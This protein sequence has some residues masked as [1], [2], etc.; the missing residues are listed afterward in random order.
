M[1]GP[2]PYFNFTKRTIEALRPPKRQRA[3]YRDTDTR[4][5]GLLVQ[6]SG[7]RSFIWYRKVQGR[8]TWRT[9]GFFPELSI[10]QARKAAAEYNAGIAAWK[11]DSYQGPAPTERPRDLTLGIVLE[12]YCEKRL[13][14][15]SKNPERAMRYA[16]WQF[17]TY[18]A[19]WR[20]R[21]LGSIQRADVRDMQV[22]VG[23]KHGRFTANRVLQ[24]VRALFNWAR[25][26]EQWNGEN[27]AANIELY[28]EASRERFVQPAEAPKLFQALAA[29]SNL[30]LRDYVLL[31][32]FTGARK[33]DVLGMRWQ[34]LDLKRGLWMIPET[35]NRSPHL[36]PLEA[37][38]LQI[39]HARQRRSSSQWVFPGT[40]K[41]GHLLD[42]KRS[43]GRLLRNAKIADLRKH[44]LR[45]TLG[46]WEA[47]AGV[48]LP[49]I[50]K[51]L[52]HRS[53]D[54]TEVYARLHLDPVR[55][56]I[57]LA[58]GALL[59]AGKVSKRKLLKAGKSENGQ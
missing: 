16:R 50:G 5:L 44:D 52:G 55:D 19:G 51:T 54:A 31:S 33:A 7:H 38:P 39:L 58:T 42:L 6:P 48:S 40:G 18:V 26:T 34:D 22:R 20:N 27:P 41:D 2:E 45:R 21:K 9:I 56:A 46:S 1:R 59:A 25:K 53:S 4:G 12:D 3:L 47:A 32:L 36:V 14:K 43:W 35:K 57:R 24:L 37:E 15:H 17:K 30:D 11:A 10:E 28:P 13:G 23:E 8:P 49:V 29:E